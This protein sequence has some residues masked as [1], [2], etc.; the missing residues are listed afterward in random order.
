MIHMRIK[1]ILSAILAGSLLLASCGGSD[2]GKLTESGTTPGTAAVSETE[3]AAPAETSGIIFSDEVDVEMNVYRINTFESRDAV[4]FD[5]VPAAKIDCYKWVDCKEY[6][7][8]AKLVY[9]RDWGFL[10]QMTCLEEDPAATYEKPD[11]PVCLDSCMEFFA[12]WDAGLGGD[13]YLNIESN[14]KGVCCT[15]I[16]PS[17]EKRIPAFRKLGGYENLF[18]VNPVVEDDRWSLTMEIPLEKL[19]KLYRDISAD[20]FVSGYTFTGNFYKTGGRDITGNEHYGMWNEVMT[21]TPDFHQ[22]A[23][24][25]KFIME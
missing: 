7:A 20:T 15:Q 3:T 2:S 18:E 6:D 11:D 13:E 5:S 21:E 17:R 10:C 23:Y 4:D 12:I 22:P 16:G 8:W 19:Q 9:V 25:G 24:F 14:S 1:L